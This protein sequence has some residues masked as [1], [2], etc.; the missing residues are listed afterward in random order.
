MQ[1]AAD[2]LSRFEPSVNAD[3]TNGWKGHRMHLYQAVSF[4]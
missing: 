1:C 3:V 4:G 2:D